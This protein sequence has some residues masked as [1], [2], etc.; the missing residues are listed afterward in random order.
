[1][2]G[3]RGIEEST[4]P[5]IP[6]SAINTRI[7][8]IPEHPVG[9][10]C[11]NSADAGRMARGKI[12][13][14]QYRAIEEQ[15]GP[16]TGGRTNPILISLLHHHPMQLHR[17]DPEMRRFHLK[18]LGASFRKFIGIAYGQMDRLANAKEFIRFCDTHG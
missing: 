5:L 16:F 17:I 3:R 12:T 1:M 10:L 18:T 8:W 15:M 2:F 11:W 4:R 7:E 13:G 14:E 6:G 9:I